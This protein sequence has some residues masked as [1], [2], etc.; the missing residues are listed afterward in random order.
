MSEMSIHDRIRTDLE[1]QILSGGLK[2]GDRIPFEMEL[3]KQYGCARMTVNK[4][5]APL[6]AAGLIYRRKR[7]GSFVAHPRTHSM[8][9]EVPDLPIEV[10]GRGQTYRYELLTR[11]VRKAVRSNEDER[12]LAGTGRIMALTGVHYADD[13]PLAFEERLISLAAVPDIEKAD[14]STEPPGSWLLHHVPWTMA[15]NRIGAIGAN[16]Q[17]AEV[18]KLPAGWPCLTIERRTWRG[19]DGITLVRQQFV[20]GEYGLI[21]RFGHTAT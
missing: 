8:V 4:A 15:E 5:L 2:P 16:D 1:T 12:G 17:I 7:V 19:D 21:A 10:V 9:L 13:K 6:V 3:M 14:F 11:D 18:L 20:A